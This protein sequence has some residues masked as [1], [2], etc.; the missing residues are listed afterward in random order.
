MYA[1]KSERGKSQEV[2][3]HTLSLS[4]THTPVQFHV[5][6]AP[7]REALR[8]LL[9]MPFGSGDRDGAAAFGRERERMLER[10]RGV[11]GRTRRKELSI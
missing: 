6:H 5:I 10:E 3:T 1:R 4:H 11:R 7:V 2:H 9:V 8:V